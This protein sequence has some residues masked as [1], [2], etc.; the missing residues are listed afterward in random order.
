MKQLKSII[1]GV[2]LLAVFAAAADAQK[3]TT[4]KTAVKN[5]SAVKTI[6]PLDV[7]TARE[8]TET[9][10][11]N[12]NFWIDKLGPIAESLESLDA[13][14]AKKRPTAAA[15]AKQEDNKKKFVAML[16]NLRDDLGMLESDFRTKPALRK[17][18]ANVDGVS[19]FAA[20]AEDSAIAGKF[21]ASK[22]PLREASKKL[23]DALAV[24]PR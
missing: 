2:L 12:V 19:N 24:I 9:Q 7:R 4:K 16:R 15:L 11:D 1:S 23:T 8:K 20:Q 18:L 21:V 14:Y 22:Q 3:K 17:Y 10:R 13:A 6:P 5:A